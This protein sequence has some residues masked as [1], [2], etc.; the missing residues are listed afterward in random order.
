MCSSDLKRPVAPDFVQIIGHVFGFRR[1]DRNERRRHLRTGGLRLR[2]GLFSASCQSGEHH[3]RAYGEACSSPIHRALQTK[4]LR[5][6]GYFIRITA[7][8]LPG[9]T[10]ALHPIH[11]WSCGL[12][13]QLYAAEAR[14]GWLARQLDYAAGCL[15]VTLRPLL[16]SGPSTGVAPVLRAHV[17]ACFECRSG[18]YRCTKRRIVY[19]VEPV[20]LDG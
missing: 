1:H 12:K 15:F 13:V 8:I 18:D 7:Q 14:R 11:S 20:W 4:T 10:A 16:R 6:I 19:T 2:R 3:D 9:F 5:R 17:R